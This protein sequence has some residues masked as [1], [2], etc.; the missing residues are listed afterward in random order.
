MTMHFNLFEDTEN[1]PLAMKLKQI[2]RSP[3]IRVPQLSRI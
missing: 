3:M 1:S 2:Q